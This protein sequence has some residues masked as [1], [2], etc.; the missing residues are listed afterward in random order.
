MKKTHSRNR[1]YAEPC[2]PV[3]FGNNY[4]I[5]GNYVQVLNLKRNLQ[6]IIMT[7]L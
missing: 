4:I 3:P 5:K 1:I 2:A 7:K 6:E